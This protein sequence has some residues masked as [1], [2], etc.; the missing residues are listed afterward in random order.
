[1]NGSAEE[2]KSFEQFADQLASRATETIALESAA[3]LAISITTL[4]GN[5]LFCLA[6]YRNRA[7]KNIT[8][9]FILSLAFAD[10]LMG[11]VCMPLS[12][13]VLVKGRWMFG[14]FP[15]AMQCFLIYFLSFVSL[16]TITLIA[17][18]R[19]YRVVR[20]AKYCH[21][22]TARSTALMVAGIWLGTAVAL[23]IPLST[24]FSQ[25]V[26]NP[27]K[28]ACVMYEG[29]R[30]KAPY[31]LVI[32]GLL[33]A[34]FAATPSV[35]LVVAYYR[36]SRAVGGHFTRVTPAFYARGT[37][38]RTHVTET[39]TT[40]TLFAVVFAF[41]LCWLPVFVIEVLQA[42]AIDWW[43]LSR[44]SQLLWLYCGCLSSATN[45]FVYALTSKDIRR[46]YKRIVLCWKAGDANA[47]ECVVPG[48]A[49]SLAGVCQ[50][51]MLNQLYGTTAKV[52]TTAEGPV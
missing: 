39:S 6:L 37:A 30:A 33:L 50:S 49:L 16:Q 14:D 34:I 47:S 43:Q 2:R 41:L 15:C 51:E 42:F 19:Y 32:K 28:A 44:A 26:F 45:P 3:L 13:G 27:A 10:I 48:P 9:M 8:N 29:E 31:M 46:E 17:V 36:V 20:T 35:T 21:I 11:V 25:A 4:A 12:V 52:S 38:L 23:A 5:V 7:M 1:M 18:N 24:G 40:R 22:F